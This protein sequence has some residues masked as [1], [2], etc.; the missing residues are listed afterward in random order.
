LG[1]LV[2]VAIRQTESGAPNGV[3]VWI[4]TAFHGFLLFPQEMIEKLGLQREAAT[5]AMRPL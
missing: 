1:A 2:D 4:E 5:E 3:T